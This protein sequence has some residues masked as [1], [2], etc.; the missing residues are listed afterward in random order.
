LVD[1]QWASTCNVRLLRLTSRYPRMIP[2]PYILSIP[3]ELIAHIFTFIAKDRDP[4]FLPLTLCIPRTM[5]NLSL[6]CKLFHQ[7]VTPLLLY[8]WSNCGGYCPNEILTSFFAHIIKNTGTGRIVR[9]VCCSTDQSDGLYIEHLGDVDQFTRLINK[10]YPELVQNTFWS[11]A[12]LEEQSADALRAL[13]LTV[14]PNIEVLELNIDGFYSHTLRL[15]DNSLRQWN[16]MELLSSGPQ[17]SIPTSI[18]F[19][20]LRRIIFDQEPDLTD[21]SGNANFMSSFF[22]LPQIREIF[23]YRM[24][25]LNLEAIQFPSGVSTVETLVLMNSAFDDDA[26]YLL[27]GTCKALRKL[28]LTMDC[29]D[30]WR[31]SEFSSEAIG[32][33]VAKHAQ[34]LEELTINVIYSYQ[35]RNLDSALDSIGSHLRSLTKLQFL[36]I[37]AEVLFGKEAV[38]EEDVN[39]EDM[40]LDGDDE[41]EQQEPP[42]FSLVDVMPAS[43]QHLEINSIDIGRELA[44]EAVLA[45]LHNFL[46]RCGKNKMFSKMRS[47]I[48]SRWLEENQHYPEENELIKR[49][50]KACTAAGVEL[51]RNPST[52]RLFFNFIKHG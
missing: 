16:E 17:K 23:G 33:A 25:A 49:L 29:T 12:I 5:L 2:T 22:K 3:E 47:L 18:P 14:L 51:L 10:A 1:R 45:S 30:P 20:N 40:D 44:I 4:D 9:D 46:E 32:K 24:S 26:I 52:R 8:R 21:A 48:V 42:S 36:D 38:D 35:T 28:N 50:A 31:P 15:V 13:L 27:L 34:S 43:I 37:G 7:I 39:E 6:T 19:S 11:K 41:S